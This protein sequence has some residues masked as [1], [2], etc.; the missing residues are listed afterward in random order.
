MNPRN[1]SQEMLA[2]CI[3]IAQQKHER[4]QENLKQSFQ[5]LKSRLETQNRLLSFFDFT[6]QPKE[7]KNDVVKVL[8]KIFVGMASE[9]IFQKIHQN[10]YTS[11]PLTKVLVGVID[12]LPFFNTLP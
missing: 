2:H 5:F 1:N 12:R 7:H 6:D 9:K 3:G 11:N 10:T 8:L 4:S